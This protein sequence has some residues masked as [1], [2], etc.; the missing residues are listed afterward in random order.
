M[1]TI[2]LIT[3]WLNHIDSDDFHKVSSILFNLI[4]SKFLIYVYCISC[5]DSNVKLKQHIFLMNHLP[6]I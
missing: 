2:S 5:M 4:D 6:P 1:A 3:S